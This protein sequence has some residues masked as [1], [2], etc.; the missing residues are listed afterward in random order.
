[1]QITDETNWGPLDFIVGGALLF[2]TGLL[3]EVGRPQSADFDGAG[4]VGVLFL[5]AFFVLLFVASAIMFQ[6]A[7]ETEPAPN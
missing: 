1:M 7:S 3:F 4:L 2:G 5:N 6:R